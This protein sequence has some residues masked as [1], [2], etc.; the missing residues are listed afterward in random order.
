MRPG[1][2]VIHKGLPVWSQN[3]SSDYLNYSHAMLSVATVQ[4]SKVLSLIC[5][6]Q[7]ERFEETAIGYL[8]YV[9]EPGNR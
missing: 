8:A 9:L 2:R 4:Y 6:P 7:I 5:I 3:P 1:Y